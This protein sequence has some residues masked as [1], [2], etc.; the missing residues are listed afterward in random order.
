M[1]I[2]SDIAIKNAR[3]YFMV[4]SEEQKKLASIVISKVV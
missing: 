4:K 3:G 2:Q 1:V